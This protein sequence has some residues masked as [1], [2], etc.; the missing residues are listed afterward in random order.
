[1]NFDYVRSPTENA[2]SDTPPNI[3]TAVFTATTNH[4][5]NA[6]PKRWEGMFVEITVTGGNLWYF[7]DKDSDAEV[8]RTEAASAAGNT[9][10]KVGRYIPSGETRQVIIPEAP[11]GGSMYFVRESDATTTVYMGLAS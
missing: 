3:S 1:M 11:A 4:A 2:D 9:G 8:D 10:A 6:V 5:A 7:F